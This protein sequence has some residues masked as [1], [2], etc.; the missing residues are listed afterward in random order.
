MDNIALEVIRVAK[1]SEHHQA[2]PAEFMGAITEGALQS[3]SFQPIPT[4]HAI[5]SMDSRRLLQSS[6][7]W[8]HNGMGMR[9]FGRRVIRVARGVM[10]KIQQMAELHDSD[11]VWNN[12]NGG[13]GDPNVET[14]RRSLMRDMLDGK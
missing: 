3:R 7:A 11:F 1:D 13:F 12:W 6:K 9:G 14:G 2:E 8:N 4:K 5:K 10:S